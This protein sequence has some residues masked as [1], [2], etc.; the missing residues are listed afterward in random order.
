M[1]SIMVKLVVML[2]GFSRNI[3]IEAVKE[4]LQEIQ[5]EE[6]HHSLCS[7]EDQEGEKGACGGGNGK[8]LREDH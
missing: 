7:I 1:S 3:E 2:V 8:M 4:V 6:T 5:E